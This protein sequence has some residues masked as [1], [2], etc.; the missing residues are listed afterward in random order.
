MVVCT[1]GVSPD[2]VIIAFSI[3]EATSRMMSFRNNA[4]GCA[5]SVTKQSPTQKNYRYR[6]K[7]GKFQSVES[8]EN[9]FPEFV[10][11]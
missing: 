8:Y 3:K 7:H 4:L 6:S 9:I 1:S 11:S 10:F 5:L 2:P